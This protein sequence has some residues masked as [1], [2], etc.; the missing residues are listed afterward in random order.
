MTESKT[1]GRVYTPKFLVDIIL[2]HTEYT[3]YDNIV[4]KH[5]IDNSCGDG[6]FLTEIVSRYCKVFDGTVEELAK[7]LQTYR[8]LHCHMRTPNYAL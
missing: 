1:Y 7:H 4:G 8:S 3:S 5:I 2:D 6:A